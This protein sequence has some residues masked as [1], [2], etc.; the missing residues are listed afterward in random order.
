ML[1]TFPLV[2]LISAILARGDVLQAKTALP[3]RPIE[4]IFLALALLWMLLV[5]L[6]LRSLRASA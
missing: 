4:R 6:R 1:Q 3:G 2:C 5:A